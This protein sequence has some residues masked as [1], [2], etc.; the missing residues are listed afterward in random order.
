MDLFFQPDNKQLF[1]SGEEAKHCTKVFRYST[2]DSILITDGR[3]TIEEVT[4]TSVETNKVFY[5]QLKKLTIPDRDYKVVI[6]VAPTRKAERNEWMVEK[7]TEM[8]VDEI[9]FFLSDHT[10]KESARRV[11]N[12]ERLE[13]IAVAAMKQ[14][15]QAIKPIITLQNSLHELVASTPVAN[16]YIAYVSEDFSQPHLIEQVVKHKDTLV[17]IGP[18][19]DFSQDEI[20]FSFENG[21]KAVSLGKTRLRTETAAFAACHA[22]HLANE[23]NK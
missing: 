2:G 4:I 7:L 5:S 11:V 9:R 18:E 8:G 1:L 22:V 19:G 15:K 14:S 10:H 16:R 21:F 17:L 20:N 13:R 12:A 6:G 23:I 3:G